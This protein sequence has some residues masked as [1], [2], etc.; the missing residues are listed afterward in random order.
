MKRRRLF[1]IFLSC[2]LLLL[3]TGCWDLKDIEKLSFVR[4]VG[5]D[6]EDDNGVK[7]TYQNLVP[8]MG[9]TQEADSLAL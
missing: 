6:E 9:G 4:G 1:L 2:C 3:S 5:I 8:K 7:L